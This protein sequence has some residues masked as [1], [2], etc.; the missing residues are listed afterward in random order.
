MN[1]WSWEKCCQEAV[2]H[3]RLAGVTHA[4]NARTVGDW[5]RET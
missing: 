3:L 5:Y 4:K 1:N 2:T